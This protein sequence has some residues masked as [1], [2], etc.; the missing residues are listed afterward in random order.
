MAEFWEEAFKNKQEMWGLEPAQSA[1]LTHDFFV[2]HG[3]KNILIPGIGYGRNAKIFKDSGLSVTGIEISQTAIDLAQKH[4]GKDLT[5]YH[6]SVTDMPFDQAL[7]DGIFCYGLIHLL[8]K[9]ERIKL[10]SDCYKQLAPGGYLVFTTITKE[11]QTYG[12]GTLI[13]KDRFALFGGVNLFFYDEATLQEE[14]GKAG[15][16]EITTVTENYPFYLIKCQKKP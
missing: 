5:I 10:I 1:V 8:D 15:L 12:Q 11:A 16:F 2:S 3:V 9:D 13:S 4:F 7:Y 14:F 6:G